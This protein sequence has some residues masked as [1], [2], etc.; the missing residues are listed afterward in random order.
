M[1]ASH[2]CLF[3]FAPISSMGARC[4]ACGKRNEPRLFARYRSLRPQDV[5]FDRVARWLG[6]LLTLGGYAFALVF[7]ELWIALLAFVSLIFWCHAIP[8]I[9]TGRR[10]RDRSR[11]ERATIA[12]VQSIMLGGLLLMSL[13][14]MPGQ[15]WSQW[16]WGW[17][18]IYAAGMTWTWFSP[19]LSRKHKGKS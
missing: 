4:D 15:A 3:C 13:P 12:R 9:R 17:S 1:S 5:R 6:A 11:A 18:A 16:S 2:A 14:I 8:G 10:L 7:D 19:D